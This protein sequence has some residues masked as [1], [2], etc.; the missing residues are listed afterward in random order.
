MRMVIMVMVAVTYP[1]V[2]LG[3]SIWDDNHELYI[4]ATGAISYYSP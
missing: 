2:G 1:Y 3:P 4:D